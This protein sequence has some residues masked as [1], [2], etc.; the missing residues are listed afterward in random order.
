MGEA[1]DI[2][3]SLDYLRY[4]EKYTENP[5]LGTLIQ[6]KISVDKKSLELNGFKL[7][8][9]DF[10]ALSGF[11]PIAKLKHLSLDQTGLNSAGLQPLCTS[12]SFINLEKLTLANNNLDDEA[13][14]FLS[15]CSSLNHLE[16]LNVSS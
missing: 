10:K 8:E 15:K 3:D 11:N 2:D 4:F 16:S 12:D 6:E 5:D 9:E 1:K 14:F 7:K 13:I